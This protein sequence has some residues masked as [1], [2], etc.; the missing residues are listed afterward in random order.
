MTEGPDVPFELTEGTLNIPCIHEALKDSLDAVH[1]A[2]E[3]VAVALS[4]VPDGDRSRSLLLYAQKKL[5][6]AEIDIACPL[7][8]ITGWYP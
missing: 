5:D 4:I 6:D 2:Q 3:R 8:I 1:E 7:R